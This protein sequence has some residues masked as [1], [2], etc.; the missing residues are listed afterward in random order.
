MGMQFGAANIQSMIFLR[1]IKIKTPY[2]S[3]TSLWDIYMNNTKP[4]I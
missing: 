1:K 4:L 2:Y 3:V